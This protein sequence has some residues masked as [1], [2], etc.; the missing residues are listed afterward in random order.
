MDYLKIYKSLIQN[1]ITDPKLDSYKEKHHIVPKCMGGDDSRENLVLLTARQHFIAHWLLFKIYKNFKLANAWHSMCRIGKGQEARKINSR[2]FEYCKKQR[3]IL[4]AINSTGANNNFYGKTHSAETRLLISEK[5]TGNIHKTEETIKKWVNEVAKKPKTPEHRS[6]I[7]AGSKGYLVFQ[8]IQTM[9]LIRI[10]REKS[11]DL[12]K[13][14]WVHP[15]KLKPEIKFKCDHCEI[16]T[17]KS[18]LKR[19][20]NQNCKK[21]ICL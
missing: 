8:N 17:T 19:W 6:K 2:K 9:E 11:I 10:S 15:R 4:L 18:N 21:R 7:A 13:N 3:S 1:A 5:L 20:H 14:L 16:I 12:D